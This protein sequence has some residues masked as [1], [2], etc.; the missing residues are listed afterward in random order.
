[1]GDTNP[2]LA[3]ALAASKLHIEIGY[4]EAGLKGHR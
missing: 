2:V 1:M 4:V 3:G